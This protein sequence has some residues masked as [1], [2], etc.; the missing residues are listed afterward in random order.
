M[1][2]GGSWKFLVHNVKELEVLLM[3]N[4]SRCAEITPNISSKNSKA[5]VE[6]A[7][8]GAI[9]VA[10]PNASLNSEENE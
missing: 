5:I 4:K 1:L 10:N 8:R 2:A 9:R 6:R 7:A 3:Y